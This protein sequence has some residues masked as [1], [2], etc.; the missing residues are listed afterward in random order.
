MLLC[1]SNIKYFI[2]DSIVL[3]LSMF[4]SIFSKKYNIITLWEKER[5]KDRY[6]MILYINFL[7]NLSV[8]TRIISCFDLATVCFLWRCFVGSRRRFSPR[9]CGRKKW[10][11]EGIRHESRGF[12][13]ARF[14]FAHRIR[15]FRLRETPF[16]FST[17]CLA[18][19]GIRDIFA[20]SS[21]SPNLR[22]RASALKMYQSLSGYNVLSW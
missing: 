14:V 5:G 18:S 7:N 2:F 16:P 17:F 12:P 10:Q 8:F 13:S 9:F 1:I 19:R 4:L 11:L 20:L 21:T 6:S 22:R 3:F 15:E